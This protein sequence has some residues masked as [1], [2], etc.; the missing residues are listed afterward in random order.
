MVF[1]EQVDVL[2]IGAGLAG[3]RAAIEA[4]DQKAGVIIANKGA[5]CR[6]GASS[7]MAGNAFQAALYAPDSIESHIKDTITGGKYLNN[8][9]LV[10]TFLE[11]GP[12]AVE[13]MHQ[14]GARFSKW[15]G[16]FY[17]IAFPGHSYPRSVAGKP[18]LFLGPEYRKALYRQV[19]NRKIRVDEDLFITELIVNDNEIAGAVGLDIRSGKP[20]VYRA[21][22][23]IL[24]TGGYMGCYEFTTA[25]RTATGDG[26]GMACRAGAVMMDMEFIQFIPS[27]TLWPP[28]LYGNP[29]PYLLWVS[30]HPAFYNNLGERFLERYF[31]DDKDW[32]ARE[33]AARAMVKEVRAGR[34][35]PHGGVYMSFRHIP[36]NL[37]ESFLDKASGS[38]YL[39]MLKEEGIDIRYDGIEIA[40]GAHYVQGGC[41]INKK[42]ETSIDGLYAVGEVGSGGKD[43]ADRLAGNSITF[44]LAMGYVAG[45]EAAKR[46]RQKELASMDA[47]VVNGCL[48]A[49]KAPLDKKEGKSPV[50]IKKQLQEIMAACAFLERDGETLD[51]GLKKLEKI[52][53]EDLPQLATNAKNKAFNLEWMEA[54]EVENMLDAA[55]LTCR[56]A[57]IREESRGLHQR[58]DYPDSD[59]EWLKHI[60][61]QKRDDGLKISF[62]PVEFPIL[63]PDKEDKDAAGG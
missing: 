61:L 37:I 46:L 21:K 45:K 26:H 44:C 38:E 14:W 2:I 11:F 63:R 50:S 24:A 33:A 12:K 43:G 6:D 7:W 1:E 27:A 51:N 56:A 62:E 22:S 13:D 52:R 20:K 15:K 41:A 42:C 58:S 59:S 55:E 8:Q 16:K 19:K 4:S 18:G 47:D 23:V 5:L 57:L 60:L 30:L 28:R 3:I 25:N 54:L 10:K 34:G 32:V 29:Y 9:D 17:Q 53:E 48:N 49:I 39:A 31:P 36:R 35:S 40:P